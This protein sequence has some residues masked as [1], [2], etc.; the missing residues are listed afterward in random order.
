VYNPEYSNFSSLKSMLLN[1]FVCAGIPAVYLL[2]V[3]GISAI[4]FRIE[5]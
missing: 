1:C 4:N 5:R 2:A 3:W